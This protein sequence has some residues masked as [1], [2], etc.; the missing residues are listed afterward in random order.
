MFFFSFFNSSAT[1]T[2]K[3][4]EREK[5]ERED[6]PGVFG[7]LPWFHFLRRYDTRACLV[8]L[9]L[10]LDFLF[11]FWDAHRRVRSERE[12]SKIPTRI[13]RK[14]VRENIFCG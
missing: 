9:L 10:L 12:H 11:F 6:P 8:A 1:Q 13:E 3:Q 4:K 14:K 2:N 5:R 7:G